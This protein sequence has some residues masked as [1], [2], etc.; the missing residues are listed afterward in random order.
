MKLDKRKLIVSCAV[1]LVAVA[2][3]LSVKHQPVI[4][5]SPAASDRPTS[6]S[7]SPSQTYPVISP[8]VGAIPDS[9]PSTEASRQDAI[10]Q[11]EATPILFFG[12]VI[13]QY[14]LPVAGARVTYT[15][16]H[17][18][19][20]GNSP[21]EGPVTDRD[22][23]FEVQTQGPS[24]TV[25]V[26]HPQY[27]GGEG[28]ER[29]V[30]YRHPSAA[31]PY[32]PKPT[33]ENPTLFRLVRKGPAENLVQVPSK[34]L[35][36]PLNGQAVEINLGGRPFAVIARLTSSSTALG[37][38]QF[39]RFDWTISLAVSNGGLIERL[40]SLDFKAPDT[41]YLP[42]A[43]VE[44]T[45][46][47]NPRWSSRINKDYFVHFSDGRYGRFQI[48]VSGD[49]GFCRFKSYLNPSGSRNLE[50]DEKEFR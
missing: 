15:V 22:G 10:A 7:P 38:N 21:I 41:G 30:D 29:Q 31:H 44:M 48:T 18:R 50:Y 12:K 2:I 6:A 39:K 35:R 36:L 25:S 45:A 33:K 1:V 46:N 17:L 14:D 20:S 13:D 11:L 34:E 40:N 32:S 9:T 28:A 19:F 24:L 8:V 49:T 37:P 47:A 5:A 42:E 3:I 4:G 16:H 27:Y 43:S 26:S 23:G